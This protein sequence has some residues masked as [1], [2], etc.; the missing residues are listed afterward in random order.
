[1][2]QKISI[3]SN[4]LNVPSEI[5]NVTSKDILNAMRKDKVDLTSSEVLDIKTRL[6]EL[7]K[8]N[9][10]LEFKISE[11]SNLKLLQD[12]APSLLRLNKILQ[13]IHKKSI[14]ALKKS[15]SNLLLLDS[16]N[17]EFSKLKTELKQVQETPMFPDPKYLNDLKKGIEVINNN[18][19][20]ESTKSEMIIK[21]IE[22]KNSEESLNIYKDILNKI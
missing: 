12:S 7:E 9:A 11:Y 15:D 1:M 8:H 18:I 16:F 2:N 14:N 19:L 17:K 5:K 4:N 13:E 21:E 3:T 10:S 20:K 6:L 22:I